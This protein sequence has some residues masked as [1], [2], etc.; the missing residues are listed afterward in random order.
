MF[1]LF[2]NDCVLLNPSVLVTKFSDDTTVIGLISDGDEGVY[3][4]EVERLAGWRS[5]NN[6]VL[7]VSKTEEM[8]IDFCKA[9][10]PTPCLMINAAGVELVDSF[11]FLSFFIS[12]DLSWAIN[13]SSIVKRCHMRLHCL[14]RL[15]RF[16]L[17]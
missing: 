5:D 8:I 9:K 7:N 11:K 14:R 17:N 6:L 4:T 16:G 12:T 15:K 3:R 1:T 10:S 2:T 13:C